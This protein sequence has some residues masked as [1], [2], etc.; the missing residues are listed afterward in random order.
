MATLELKEIVDNS[1][2][3]ETDTKKI[4]SL[5]TDDKEY[6]IEIANYFDETSGNQSTLKKIF[7]K[8]NDKEL[9]SYFGVTA[10]ETDG[11]KVT[12]K[13][14]ETCEQDIFEI[15]DEFLK[16]IEDINFPTEKE[17]LASNIKKTIANNYYTQD[18]IQS[19]IDSY[20]D[21]FKEVFRDIVEKKHLEDKLPNFIIYSNEGMEFDSTNPNSNISDYLK[22]SIID[23]ED[24]EYLDNMNL[25]D[26]E[27][28]DILK[29]N[30]LVNIVYKTKDY[31][32]RDTTEE[33][34][35]YDDYV[36]KVVKEE[37]SKELVEKYDKGELESF[38]KELKN[39]VL[40]NRGIFSKEIKKSEIEEKELISEKTSEKEF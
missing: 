24:E 39:L 2:H 32:G 40:E 29:E 4:Y 37:L 22:N 11:K 14:E 38:E 10:M 31:L 13:Y 34:I 18:Y 36:N 6:K 1:N 23:F 28:W 8:N 3:Y 30:G 27:E 20:F 9:Y 17:I 33:Y 19:K 35:D 12:Q 7:D 26:I 25:K 16:K 15:S 5:K 21:N